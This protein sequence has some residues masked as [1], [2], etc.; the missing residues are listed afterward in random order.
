M[1]TTRI[2]SRDPSPDAGRDVIGDGAERLAPLLG[3]RLA[4]V[5]RAEQHHLVAGRGRLVAEVDDELVHADRARDR[6]AAA[7]R[8][9]Q[10]Q[11][12][13]APRHP[14]RVPEGHQAEGGLAGRHVPVAVRD[15][16]ARGHPLDH[17]QPGAQR[18]RRAQP[19]RRAAGQGGQAVDGPAEAHQVQPGLRD[20]QRGGGVGDVPDLGR[21]AGLLGDRDRVGERGELGGDRRVPGDVG[22]GEVRPQARHPDRAAGLGVQGGLHHPGPVRRG[23]AAPAQPGVGLE[24]QPGPD[25]GPDGRGL[26]HRDERDRAGRDVDVEADRLGGVAEGHQ[27]QHRRGDPGPPERDRLGQVG[28]AQ[29][30]G[31]AGQRGPGGRDHAVAVP[32]GLHHGHHL[33]AAHQL[34]QRGDVAGDRAEVDES[35]PV[36]A[37]TGSGTRPAAPGPGPRPRSGP[38]P[39]RRVRRS[40]GPPR[41]AARPGRAGRP[42]PGPPG[43]AQGPARA[44]RRPAR[45][46]RRRC[47]RWPATACRWGSP[48]RARQHPAAR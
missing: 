38:G 2:G 43:R 3:G 33:A 1:G 13:R 31:P 6:P 9:D 45:T 25:A 26:D 34:A 16:G 18:H 23:G 24:V 27:A 28:D 11:A 46:A 12:G 40:P 22:A 17:G 30:A 47:P 32:V 29:P 42:P 5:P 36:H 20:G 21:D 44:A 14:V 10:R 15:A 35:L 7:A 48:G 19:R 37:V 8:A 39:A 41:P 4:A